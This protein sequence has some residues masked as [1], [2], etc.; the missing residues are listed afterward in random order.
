MIRGERL[1]RLKQNLNTISESTATDRDTT[2][3][4]TEVWLSRVSMFSY[5]SRLGCRDHSVS[6]HMKYVISLLFN[7][8]ALICIL[9]PSVIVAQVVVA[10]GHK[11]ARTIVQLREDAD[12]GDA[13]AMVL[14]G[15]H[16]RDA[17]DPDFDRAISWLSLIHI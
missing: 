2:S 7:L 1:T 4:W 9:E 8:V 13:N 11:D 12:S 10:Q 3:Q 6:M 17:V 14:L 16:Y 5:M 15:E